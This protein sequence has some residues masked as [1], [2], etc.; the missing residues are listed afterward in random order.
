MRRPKGFFRHLSNFCYES[1]PALVHLSCQGFPIFIG[2]DSVC[3]A[4]RINKATLTSFRPLRVHLPEPPKA[5]KLRYT[6]LTLYS[7]RL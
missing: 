4:T 7:F 6:F 5:L 1:L 2:L 3:T